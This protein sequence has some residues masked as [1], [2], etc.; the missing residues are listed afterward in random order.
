[1]IRIQSSPDR[2]SGETGV[3]AAGLLPLR[4]PGAEDRIGAQTGRLVAIEGID[5]A[6]KT[7]ISQQLARTLAD[8]GVPAE[9]FVTN[10]PS[11]PLHPYWQAVDDASNV[12]AAQGSPVPDLLVQALHTFEFLAYCTRLLSGALDRS[13]VVIA[14]RYVH[15]RRMLCRWDTEDPGC[16]LEELLTCCLAAGLLP[17]PDLTVFLRIDPTVA[18][19]RINGRGLAR[20]PKEAPRHLRRMAEIME[21][22]LESPPLRDDES[23]VVVDAVCSPQR[24][25]ERIRHHPAMARL[26]R[27]NTLP[28]N[29]GPR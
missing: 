23:V 20:E 9:V 27:P 1:M 8:E 22:L 21:E 16:Y 26:P 11:R 2:R 6:G 17:R 4:A 10:T 19:A 29:G 28:E 15:S 13:E 3:P 14:D 12:M 18:H 7:T 24:I 5:G 25:V